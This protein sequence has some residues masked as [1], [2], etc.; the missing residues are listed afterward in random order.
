[1]ANFFGANPKVHSYYLVKPHLSEYS[2]AETDHLK[3]YNAL[4]PASQNHANDKMLKKN[5]TPFEMQNSINQ[6]HGGNLQIF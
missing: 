5:P 1:L 6:K 2:N 3:Y 4:L